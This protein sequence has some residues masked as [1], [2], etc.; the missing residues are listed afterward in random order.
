MGVL[1]RPALVLFRSTGKVDTYS[2][3]A[4]TTMDFFTGLYKI[5]GFRHSISNSNAK[6]E[7]FVYKDI[8]GMLG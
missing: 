2:E 8:A 5:L 7:F 4:T 1:T 3:S 6:S